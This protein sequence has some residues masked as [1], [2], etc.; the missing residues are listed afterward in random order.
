MILDQIKEVGGSKNMVSEGLQKSNFDLSWIFDNLRLHLG[1]H[2]EAIW[3]PRLPFDSPSGARG[4]EKGG[5]E[6]RSD[7]NIEKGATRG[8]GHA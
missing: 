5:P 2:S 8:H 1:V 4:A 6:K 3:G 7:F